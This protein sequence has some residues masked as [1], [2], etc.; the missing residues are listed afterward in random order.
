MWSSAAFRP[1]Y[2]TIYCG[3]FAV[4]ALVALRQGSRTAARGSPARLFLIGAA[5]AIVFRFVPESLR[6]KTS[7]IPLRHP[8]KFSAAIV[9]GLAVLA[10]LAVDRF[11]SGLRRPAWVL[12][13][14]A[15]LA[16]AAVVATKFPGARRRA[17]GE[18]DGAAP[19][20]ALDAGNSAG[21]GARR[22]GSPLDVD[23]PRAIALLPGGR[24]G[25]LRRRGDPHPRAHRGESPDRE[26]G[27][28]SERSRTHDVRADDRA[29]RS[30]RRVP[31]PGREGL[32][33][34]VAALGRDVRRSVPDRDRSTG[35]V[36]GDAGALASR[37]GAQPRSRSSAISRA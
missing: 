30:A 34:P 1:L 3:A 33:F 27:P 31:D 4:V 18:L 12:S 35:L 10:G 7:W 16:A 20:A 21:G 6:E 24:G 25:A 9:L 14:A 29:A 37:H 36:L 22:G 15:L 11:R 28:R 19:G 32:P 23:R 5:L 13:G 2:S 17:R 26:N 8:E